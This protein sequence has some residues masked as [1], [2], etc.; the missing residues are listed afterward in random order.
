MMRRIV[1][2]TA[3]VMPFDLSSASEVSRKLGD[4]ENASDRLRTCNGNAAAAARVLKQAL[5]FTEAA[6]QSREQR[7]NRAF[8]F[9]AS[10]LFSEPM[11]QLLAL[12]GETM[13]QLGATPIDTSST[14]EWLHLNEEL[15]EWLDDVV[16]PAGHRSGALSADHID[17]LRRTLDIERRTADD[18]DFRGR[19]SGQYRE[20]AQAASADFSAEFRASVLQYTGDLGL[21]DPEPPARD[22]YDMTLILGG[23]YKS[24]QLRAK[25]AAQLASAGVD[26][27]DLYFLGSPRFLI[28]DPPEAP[29]VRYY[30]PDANDE[31]DLMGGG[32]HHEF[33]LTPRDITFMCG[34]TSDREM[35]P[36]WLQAHAADDDVSDTPPQYTH[37]RQTE[38]VDGDGNRRGLVISASTHRPPYRPD[39]SDTFALWSRVASPH[40]GQR[41]LIVTTQVFVPFQTFDGVRRLYLDHGVQ[42]DAVGFGADW[43][44]RPLTAE[45]VLQETLSA[46]RSA[47]RLLVDATQILRATDLT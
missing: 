1:E 8:D 5:L 10:W 39:T 36:R 32:A 37:E 30:A 40:A 43:G 15:P 6:G 25:L 9:A 41:A 44:D 22:R 14:S 24:P 26:L 29:Q 21:V 2:L 31:F 17:V 16:G 27:G 34:C 18:F 20:R 13:P 23:G 4:H 33:G 11:S 42:V 12:F 45:Y 47:R 28:A 3:C 38:L 46:I 19:G 35:C 7:A